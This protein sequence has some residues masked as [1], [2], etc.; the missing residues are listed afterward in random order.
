MHVVSMFII[1]VVVVFSNAFFCKLM[2]S[3]VLGDNT[4]HLHLFTSASVALRVFG[5]TTKYTC[6][7]LTMTN[8]IFIGKIWI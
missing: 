6:M 4:S 1:N 7:K 3:N 8:C 5:F 2:D